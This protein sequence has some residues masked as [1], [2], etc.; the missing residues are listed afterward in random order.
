MKTLDA[1]VLLKIANDFGSPT[2]VYDLEKITRRYTAELIKKNFI[3]PGTDV[4]APD[5]GT[6]GREMAWI[7]IP[8]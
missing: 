1:A 7:L 2:Y 8:M 6:G 3:G 4:P 5:Y